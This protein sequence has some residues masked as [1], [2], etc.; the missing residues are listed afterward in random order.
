MKSFLEETVEDIIQKFGSELQNIEI[1]YPNKRT[2][3]HLK[4]TVG[5]LLG[6][7]VWSPD[8]YTIQKYVSNLSKLQIADRLSLL[9]E[10]FKS[11]RNVDRNFSY[12]FESFFKLGE[13]ILHDFDTGPYTPLKI[14]KSYFISNSEKPSYDLGIFYLNRPMTINIE[15]GFNGNLSSLRLNINSIL[16]N[17]E[18][19]QLYIL[20]EP[21]IVDGMISL[22][23]VVEIRNIDSNIVDFLDLVDYFKIPGQYE[24]QNLIINVKES[25][26]NS[27]YGIVVL[28][29]LNTPKGK[30]KVRDSNPLYFNI[31]L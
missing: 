2:G 5:R 18:T 24:V 6:K 30:I 1:I 27:S 29:V 23:S 28:K 19:F 22:K 15:D 11:F 7:T 10:L 14:E 21:D 17:D 4:S 26:T 8:M 16:E 12:D 13:I 31:R 20:S 9:F 25:I 3:F